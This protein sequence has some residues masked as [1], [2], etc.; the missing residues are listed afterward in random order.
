MES[1]RYVGYFDGATWY[2][3]LLQ[4]Y[5][6]LIHI[7]RTH[8]FAYV[9]VQSRCVLHCG[10]HTYHRVT[11]LSDVS[12]PL[13]VYVTSRMR[14]CYF[15]SPFFAIGLSRVLLFIFSV[16]YL[17]ILQLLSCNFYSAQ[18]FH[19]VIDILISIKLP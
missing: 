4:K 19:I 8:T 7:S 3:C 10:V 15:T 5:L 6:G 16:N 14:L 18:K 12:H 11:Y 17:S 2:N 13:H 1:D 9:C